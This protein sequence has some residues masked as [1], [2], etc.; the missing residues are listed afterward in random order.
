[1]NEAMVKGLIS[2]GYR[3]RYER[4]EEKACQWTIPSYGVG[5]SA[6]VLLGLFLLCLLFPY[7][8]DDWFWGSSF[9]L[10]QLRNGFA[11]YNGRYVGNLIVLVLTRCRLLRALVISLTLYGICWCVNGIVGRD[12]SSAFWISLALLL[13]MPSSVRAQGVAWTSGFVN[14]AIPSLLVLFYLYSFR[15]VFVSDGRPEKTRFS[16]SLFLLGLINS[17]IMENVSIYNVAVSIGMIVFTRIK[18]GFYDKRQLSF[19]F[20]SCVGCALMFSNGAYY[21]AAT[22]QSDY[23]K[24]NKGPLVKSMISK[25]CLIINPDCCLRNTAINVIFAVCSFSYYQK[26]RTPKSLVTCVTCSLVAGVSLLN[27]AGGFGQE[28]STA[29][30]KK[31]IVY[32][33]LTILM[34]V[35]VFLMCREEGNGD[36]ASL[37]FLSM[38]LIVAP[39]LIVNPVGARHFLI[40]YCL[41]VLLACLSLDR[42]YPNLLAGANT[43]RLMQYTACLLYISW[44]LLYGVIALGEFRRVSHIND[45]LKTEAPVIQI[46]AL[47]YSSCIESPNPTTANPPEYFT[48][49]F[50]AYYGIDQSVEIK[51]K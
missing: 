2:V 15:D 37:T 23:Q 32:S 48:E 46:K 19:L 1:M 45:A 33:V 21:A 43:I 31:D 47:P 34:L 12:D 35:L 17:L 18:F 16:G 14:Y 39:L 49:C 40:T 36:T 8:G 7:T 20:G 24:L 26:R 41:F 13:S 44:F 10:E 22:G 27:A 30:S 29:L 3:S 25:F 51:K 6:L 42:F 5:V 38:A 4:R 50:R 11:N 28:Q 9:G